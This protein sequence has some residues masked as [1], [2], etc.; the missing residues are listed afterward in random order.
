MNGY[1]LGLSGHERPFFFS[2]VSQ[3]REPQ[4]SIFVQFS[5]ASTAYFILSKLFPAHETMLEHA[6]LDTD[7]ASSE[8]TSSGGINDDEKK[9]RGL[10]DVSHI[11]TEKNLRSV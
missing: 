9:D 1:L 11:D 8:H 5:L 3:V 10:A 6:I 4:N 2:Q 7:E